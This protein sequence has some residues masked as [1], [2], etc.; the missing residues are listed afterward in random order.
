MLAIGEIR[1]DIQLLMIDS[2][3]RILETT[4]ELGYMEHIMHIREV[5]WE[6]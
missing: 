5:G 1:L 3:D 4:A 2:T 6:L